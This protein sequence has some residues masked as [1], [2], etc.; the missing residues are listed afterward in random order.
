MVDLVHL[1]N[2]FIK[3]TNIKKCNKFVKQLNGIENFLDF[4]DKFEISADI[5]KNDMYELMY[6]DT[7]SCKAIE[8]LINDIIDLCEDYGHKLT[9]KIKVFDDGEILLYLIVIDNKIYDIGDKINKYI[10][11]KENKIF[12]KKENKIFHKK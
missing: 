1:S 8:E 9:L 12:H 3:F 10:E 5:K 6:N 2:S 7:I 11:H 4:F